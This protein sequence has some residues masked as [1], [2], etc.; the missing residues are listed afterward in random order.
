[1]HATGPLSLSESARTLGS[2]GTDHKKGHAVS[3]RQC[4][5]QW[6]SSWPTS[7][8]PPV[9]LLSGTSQKAATHT[10]THDKKVGGKQK[11]ALARHVGPEGLLLSCSS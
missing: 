9:W 3:Q 4:A 1:M 2:A 7:L 5:D 8:H 6:L 11:T 10:C